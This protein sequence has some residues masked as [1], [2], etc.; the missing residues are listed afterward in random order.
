MEAGVEG[1]LLKENAFTD[2]LVAIETIRQGKPYISN[3]VAH[4]ILDS[5]QSKPNPKESE[6]LT[7]REKQVLKCLADGMSNK[8]IADS[9]LISESTVLIHFKNIKKKLFIKTNINLMRYA[10]KNGSALRFPS[11]RHFI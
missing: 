11:S 9:L 6:L 3:L 7:P 2:L 10:L 1:Y 8:E 4:Q 5:F